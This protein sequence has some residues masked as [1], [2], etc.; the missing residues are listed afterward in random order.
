MR[1]LPRRIAWLSVMT[2]FW[3]TVAAADG[4][5]VRCFLVDSRIHVTVVS[6]S[7]GAQGELV[8]RDTVTGQGGETPFTAK[9]DGLL[10]HG[11]ESGPV[12]ARMLPDLAILLDHPPWG[13]RGPGPSLGIALN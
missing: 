10:L 6:S 3:A 12:L 4:T 1:N 13:R 9:H 7:V 5:Q 11:T 8:W 2:L